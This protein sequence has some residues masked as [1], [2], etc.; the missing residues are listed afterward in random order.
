MM[1]P[2]VFTT[3]VRLEPAHAYEFA[4]N[5]RTAAPFRPPTAYRWRRSGGKF[6][7]RLWRPVQAF[8]SLPLIWRLKPSGSFTWKLFSVSGVGFR[9]RRSNSALTSAW[10]QF[11]MV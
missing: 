5:L 9:P 11:S 4:L 7:T 6:P 3:D 1:T 8:M 10:F 2:A